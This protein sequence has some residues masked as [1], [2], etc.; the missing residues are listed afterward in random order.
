MTTFAAQ[1]ETTTR[2]ALLDMPEEK[3]YI[4]Y[5]S[6]LISKSS[7][8]SP[9]RDL[10]KDRIKNQIRNTTHGILW[11]NGPDYFSLKQMNS[12][13]ETCLYSNCLCTS[14]RSLAKSSSAI[15]FCT[16]CESMG[17]GPPVHLSERPSDQIWIF[18]SWEPPHNHLYQDDFRHHLWKDTM[19]WS[20]T[21]R[22]DSD[23]HIPYGYLSTR[24]DVPKRNYSEIFRR[25]TKFAAWIVSHCGASSMRDSFVRK[26]QGYG[27]PVD[28][29]GKCGV[30]LYEDAIQMINNTYKFYFSLENSYCQDY[31]TEK[32]FNYFHLDTIVIA[33]GGANYGR[34]LPSDSFIDA[35][36]FKHLRDLVDYLLRVNSS[37]SLYT[38]YL[39]KKDRFTTH[40]DFKPTFCDLCAKLNNKDKN[41]RVYHDIVDY[42]Y[43]NQCHIAQDVTNTAVLSIVLFCIFFFYAVF[44]AFKRVNCDTHLQPQHPSL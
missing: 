11:F 30:P 2:P 43:T 37:E 28:I 32:F 9:D 4:K 1:P 16:T 40:R 19:N 23:I 17:P 18:M 14:N 15:L 31:V 21:Y 44:L 34:L 20:M 10:L 42:I 7:L 26:L 22:L 8:S 25:K 36:N 24:S 12:E 35:S 13:I 5:F 38:S 39:K 33:R 6:D 3:T 29:Y 41:K 27:L